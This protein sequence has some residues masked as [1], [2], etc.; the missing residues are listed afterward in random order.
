MKGTTNYPERE[1][2]SPYL[3]QWMLTQ[4]WW[5]NS[6]GQILAKGPSS[7]LWTEHLVDRNNSHTRKLVR[8][9]TGHCRLNIYMKD[10]ILTE[11]KLCR[12]SLEDEET[13]MHVLCYCKGPPPLRLLK[14]GEEKPGITS[15]TRYLLNSL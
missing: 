7:K 10:L 1:L 13:V 8:L 5:N 14:L 11:Q 6:P 3:A 15:Y 2:Q 12:F 4:V 9:F